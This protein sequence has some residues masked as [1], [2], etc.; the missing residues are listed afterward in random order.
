MIFTQ[1]GDSTTFSVHS[2]D[3]PTVYVNGTA[4]QPLRDRTDPIV[5]TLEQEMA[6]L[7]WLNPYTGNVQNDIM[8]GLADR[9][10]MNTLHMVTSDP[11]RTPTFTAFA[12]PDW[13]FFATGATNCPT[14]AACAFIPA[15]TSQSFAW[16]HGDIQEE[17]GNTWAGFIGP[18][19]AHN[20]VDSRTWTDH[21]N[22]RPTILSLTGLHDDYVT[23]GRVLIEALTTRAT[24]HALVA[25]R[26]TV[27][28][29][30][31][32]YEQINAPFGDFAHHTLKAST[33]ALSSSDAGVYDSIEGSIKDL[34]N[35]RDELVS[36]VRAALNAAAF[37]GQAI[38]E[39]QAKSWIA[40]A[41][42]LIAQAAA[43]PN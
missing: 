12:D 23:D 35:Q 28:R 43:L 41:N 40:Q 27:R 9:V 13:F 6:G 39:Q 10:E 30:G 34:T 16:N 26:E 25:H 2:D 36:H 22:L 33:R 19:V 38:N 5:R 15:R 4:A 11:F 21:T 18:G 3:A 7:D 24:P 42:H 37:D 14:Q 20:G 32:V 29:L 17:I 31:A 8:V 1:F